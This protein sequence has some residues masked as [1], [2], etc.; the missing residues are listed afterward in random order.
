MDG[1]AVCKICHAY[2]ADEAKHQA[3]HEQ[4]IKD[5]AAVAAE[6]APGAVAAGIMRGVRY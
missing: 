3:W 2:V 1:A 5:A 6:Q 4:V